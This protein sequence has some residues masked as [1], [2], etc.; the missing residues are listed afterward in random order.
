MRVDRAIDTELRAEIE[1]TT[2]CEVSAAE[3]VVGIGGCVVKGINRKRKTR[4]GSFLG[5]SMFPDKTAKR[6]RSS[7]IW[8]PREGAGQSR[9]ATLWPHTRRGQARNRNRRTEHAR[10][11]R[12]PASRW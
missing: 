6:F 3:T 2:P 1:N 11:C 7:G 4:P 9:Y 10:K 8:M 5:G 12:V